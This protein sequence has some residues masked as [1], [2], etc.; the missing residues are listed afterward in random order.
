MRW[1][2]AAREEMLE[3]LRRVKVEVGF[4][5]LD[6]SLYDEEDDDEEGVVDGFD[7]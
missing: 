6:E 2:D 4:E 5:E 1:Q 3:R 7:L